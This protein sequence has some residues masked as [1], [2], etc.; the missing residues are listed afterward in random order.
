MKPASAVQTFALLEEALQS[1]GL[2]PCGGLA[3][4]KGEVVPPG[5]TG[6]PAKAGVL[7]GHVGSS[8]WPHFVEWRRTQPETTP[9]PLD[10]WSEETIGAVASLLGLRAVFPSDR[11]WLPFQVWARRAEGLKQSPLGL[12]IHPRYGL[13]RA[14]RGAVLFDHVPGDLPTPLSIPHP[15]DTCASRPCLSACPV[16]AFDGSSYDVVGCRSH[17]AVPEGTSCLTGGC[18]ARLACPVGREHAYIAE[19]QAFHMAA[20]SRGGPD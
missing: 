8:F 14:F 6:A 18:L 4:E 17:L 12:L 9:N 7:V 11:P 15:C 2:V 3:F 5:P 1:Y 20:F 10:R 16:D 13:W 19:Q